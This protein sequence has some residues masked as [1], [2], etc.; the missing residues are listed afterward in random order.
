MSRPDH[1]KNKIVTLSRLCFQIV[2]KETAFS[3][4]MHSEQSFAMSRQSSIELD[5]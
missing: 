5:D 4:Q 1:L 2:A 3:Q